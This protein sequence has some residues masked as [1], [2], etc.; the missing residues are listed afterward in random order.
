MGAIWSG[1]AAGTSVRQWRDGVS[2][3]RRNAL[4]SK[5]YCVFF[6]L[7][8]V[9]NVV[10]VGAG[11]ASGFFATSSTTTA[12]RLAM[13]RRRGVG[14]AAVGGVS[15]D[16]S[17]SRWP[18]KIAV[19]QGRLFSIR[20]AQI[21]AAAPASFNGPATRRSWMPSPPVASLMTMIGRNAVRVAFDLDFNSPSHNA[22]RPFTELALP[23]STPN[24][25]RRSETFG[26]ASSS[27]SASVADGAT[28]TT[29]GIGLAITGFGALPGSI[30][31]PAAG[32]GGAIIDCAAISGVA[33]E[34]FA[35]SG[36][37]VSAFTI[38]AFAA[39]SLALSAL[40]ASVF[41]ASFAA[42]YTAAGP[43][44]VVAAVD[45]SV[46]VGGAGAVAAG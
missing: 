38:S 27:A 19:S 3:I 12:A 35:D 28:A 10:C 15:S 46:A 7:K 9:D 44:S 31:L 4:V 33:G 39:S 22:R 6:R 13:P 25:V 2:K 14:L 16:F 24:S 21:L 26:A 1:L 32:S 18:S 8:K 37:T 43:G 30:S 40:A 41:A 45:L 5:D 20:T 17:D 36:L 11:G 42:E 23:R 34:G 29:S